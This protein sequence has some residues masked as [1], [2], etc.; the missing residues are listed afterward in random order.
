[1]SA[2]ESASPATAPRAGASPRSLGR[3]PVAISVGSVLV[4]GLLWE[5]LGRQVPATASYPSA[6]GAALIEITVGDGALFSA[7]ADTL[8]GMAAGFLVAGVLGVAIG[9]AM[10]RI[11][12]VAG[13]VEPYINAIYAT[14]RIALIPLLVLWFGIGFQL[15]VTVAVL[16]AIFPIILNTYVG[17]SSV[18]GGLMDAGRSLNANSFQLLR[19][20]VMPASLPFVVTGLRIGGFRALVGVIVAEMT[21]S[22]TGTGQL[23]LTYGRF[24]QIPHL[25]AAIL[26]LGVIG[27]VFTQL[28]G[29]A[30]RA[31]M[32][33]TRQRRA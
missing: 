16:T 2:V 11:P 5:F 28:M 14:P 6:V 27:V 1:M 32:P 8:R 22:I 23:L 17:A 9:F 10:G 3:S 19:T 30:E 21:A 7:L 24:V 29:A 15:R 12:V 31:A 20:V 18:D 33:W 4:A 26:S 13:L 25:I